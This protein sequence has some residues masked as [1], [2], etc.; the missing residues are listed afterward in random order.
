MFRLALVLACAAAL[1]LETPRVVLDIDAKS[2]AIASLRDVTS[3]VEFAAGGAREPLFELE[4]ADGKKL[5]ADDFGD[6]HATTTDDALDV[7]FEAHPDA[8][9][10]RCD[11]S[12]RAASD[13]TVRARLRCAAAAGAPATVLRAASFPDFRQAAALGAGDALAMPWYEGAGPRGVIPPAA[14]PR[15]AAVPWRRGVVVAASAWRRLFRLFRRRSA[16]SPR[17]RCLFCRRL[18]R[19]RRRGRERARRRDK[20]LQLVLP[21]AGRIER[22]V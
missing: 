14:P 8:P 9:G 17:R 12:F 4:R 7:S 6:V 1:R 19:P 15:R 21:V 10:L 20:R 5:S 13:A 3:G 18:R 11:A 2:G 16:T 22:R